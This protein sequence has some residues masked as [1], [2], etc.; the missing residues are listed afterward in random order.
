[1]VKERGIVETIAG[2]RA[3]VRVSRSSSCATCESR[4]A[5]KIEDDKELRVEVKN[6]LRAKA[7]DQVEISMST[8]SLF[9]MGMLVYLFP[10]LAMVLGAGIGHVGAG[11]V[12]IDANLFSIMMGITALVI[13]FGVLKKIDHALRSKPEYSPRMTRVID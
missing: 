7:G 10:V 4:A 5:C 9:K 3:V 6:D 12:E 13:S 8:P 1:M 11:Y 2:D